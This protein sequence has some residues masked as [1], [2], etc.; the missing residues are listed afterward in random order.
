VQPLD[1]PTLGAA[2]AIVVMVTMLASYV[3]AYRASR[4]NPLAA[5]RHD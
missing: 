3:P 4:V 1:P 5:L 2:A